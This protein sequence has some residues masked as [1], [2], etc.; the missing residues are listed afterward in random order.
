LKCVILA[1]GFGTRLYPLTINK[2]KPL[3]EYK[4]K[5]VLTH[6][7]DRIP[8]GIDIFVSCNKRFEADFRN[9]QKDVGRKIEICVEDVWTEEQRKGAV[10]SLDFWVCNKNITED[11]LVIAGDNYFEFDLFQFMAAYDGRNAL[12]AV[13]DLGD[14]SK[15]TQFGVVE[16][17]GNRIVEL[18][19]KPAG[20]KSSLIAT[21]IYILPTKILP[22]LSRYCTEGKKDNLGSFIS[23][24]VDKDEVYAYVFTE[25]WLDI[26][27]KLSF[28]KTLF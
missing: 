9:W 24:L 17:D 1:G 2:A 4:G 6:I 28:K 8:H 11:L 21:A 3:L 27:A 14:K 12:V 5:P 20:P 15:A 25:N 26:G 18:Q 16:L 13:Y 7:V 22:L 10:G 19:E 23:Y